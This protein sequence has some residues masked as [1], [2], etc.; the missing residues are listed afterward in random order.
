M[1]REEFERLVTAKLAALQE[2]AGARSGPVAVSE[3]QVIAAAAMELLTVTLAN[4]PEPER[5]HA[6]E[7]LSKTLA[8]DVAKKRQRLEQKIPPP[9]G[10]A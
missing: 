1:L 6:V 9:E 5:S 7:R 2:A 8:T 4:M 3:L 10:S